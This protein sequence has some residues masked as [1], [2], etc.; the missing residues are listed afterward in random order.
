MN[1]NKFIASNVY[2]DTL[3]KTFKVL[4][5]HL[6]SRSASI[7]T[8][9]VVNSIVD[10]IGLAM[11]IPVVYLIND[12]API[13]ENASLNKMYLLSGIEREYI[14][15][16]VLILAMVILFALKNLFAVFVYYRQNKFAYDTALHL[17]SRQTAHFL[18]ADYK[19]SRDK[20]SN[21]Y[22]RDMATIPNE[23][24][25]SILI[26][27]IKISNEFMVLLFIIVGLFS[28]DI[29]VLLLLSVTIF[30]VVSL[31]MMLTKR[32]AD[33]MGAKKYE[34]IPI[35]FKS[36]FELVYSYTDVKLFKKEKHFIERTNKPF[37]QLFETSLW[38]NTLQRIPQ[39][40]MEFAIILAVMILYGLIIILMD[41]SEDD[42]VWVLI[43]FVTAAY[44]IMPSLNEIMS[45]TILL[46]SSQHVFDILETTDINNENQNV[47]SA[48]S[49]KESIEL[50]NIF[51]TYPGSAKPALNGLNIK[52]EKGSKVGIIGESGSG[53]TTL[54]KIILRLIQE[55]NGQFLVDGEPLGSADEWFKK[56]AYVQQ[57]F[58]IQDS[59]LAENIAFGENLAEIDKSKLNLV[60]E[61]T[62]LKELTD[63]LERG[64]FSHV[65][66]FGNNLS[67]GQKQRIAIAR[68]LYKGAEVL[69]LDEATNAL[70]T[71]MEN[72]IMQTI[73]NLADY[74]LT[75]LI[76]SHRRNT[77]QKC[78]VI[79]EIKKGAIVHTYDYYTA[80]QKM[81]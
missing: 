56:L 30:P 15:V 57:D 71:Q 62:N 37:V 77:L 14:F 2:F 46:R 61:Q 3:V 58:H 51:Y 22:V 75:V 60:I 65:G 79:Y 35:S 31:I 45:S 28:Y 67:G 12:S 78:D 17:I 54:G 66:E 41:R 4:P 26:P 49:F 25:S 64:C 68:A 6:Y 72:E 44:R 40:V 43:L 47:Q 38:I 42:L 27:L 20:N 81:D 53:K 23:F 48:I 33:E 29:K 50:R 73:Y 16:F 34:L 74:D 36:V 69:I 1:W 19:H 70:D 9:T 8:L 24:A 5:K 39:R 21:Y 7:F 63:T 32:K 10:V 13:H 55:E 11:L 80:A 76:I 18:N 52:I 59:S